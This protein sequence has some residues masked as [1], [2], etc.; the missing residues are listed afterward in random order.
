MNIGLSLAAGGVKGFSHIATLKFLEEYNVKPDIITGASAGAIVAALYG[1]YGNSQIVYEK[2]SE[3]IEKFLPD[4]K[5]Y[6]EKLEKSSIWSIFQRALVPIDQ[7]YKFFRYLFERKKF[8]DLKYKIGIITFDTLEGKSLLITEGFLVDAVMASSSVPG[9]FSPL[10]IAG[11]QN[12]DG[13]V[14]SPTPVSEAIEMG[15]DFVVASTFERKPNDFPKDQM[16]LMYYIDT[17]KEIELEYVDLE[18]ANVVIYY[19]IPYFWYQ[20]NLYKEIYEHS[21][22]FIY[23]RRKEF[24]PRFWW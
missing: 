6:T 17:W 22:K 20:F 18:K 3:G 7:Y 19:R 9:V 8:S 4:F 24:D 21:L 11:T 5:T 14:L 12:T 2:F 13:G 1:L 16:E 10:W 15:A 23:E